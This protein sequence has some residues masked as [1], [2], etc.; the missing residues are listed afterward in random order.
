M[1]STVVCSLAQ[2]EGVNV[3]CQ[4]LGKFVFGKQATVF[5][6]YISCGGRKPPSN[7]APNTAV[8]CH[9]SSAPANET[10]F[11]PSFAIVQ[12]PTGTYFIAV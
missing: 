8:I 3:T 10:F 11:D 12:H 2:W 1:Y 7:V 6:S 9:L 4:S 5:P